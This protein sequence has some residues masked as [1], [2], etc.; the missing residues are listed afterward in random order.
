MIIFSPVS[1]YSQA[2]SF[3]SNLQKSRAVHGSGE[4]ESRVLEREAYGIG[5]KC[6]WGL[7]KRYIVR[8]GWLA[9]EKARIPGTGIFI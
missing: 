6:E 8:T 3:F 1:H 7:D 5:K 2:K 4:A 9:S